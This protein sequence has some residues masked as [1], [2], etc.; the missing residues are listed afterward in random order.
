MKKI[1]E[2]LQDGETG[3]RFNTDIDIEKNPELIAPLM[4]RLAMNM[5]F[6]L[7][8]G[9]ELSVLAIIRSLAI[10]DLSLCVNRE[11]MLEYLGNSSEMLCESMADARR[12]MAKRGVKIQVFPPNMA[13][14]EIKS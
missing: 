9:N 12:Q 2:I 4:C 5:S 11:E 7:W 10:A 1:L 3:I 14:C 6:N 13:P 8:G